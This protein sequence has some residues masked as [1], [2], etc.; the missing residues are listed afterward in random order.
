M[1]MEGNCL[2]NNHKSMRVKI[3]DRDKDR[4]ERQGVG[5]EDRADSKRDGKYW[6]MLAI[7][8]GDIEVL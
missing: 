7:Q 3:R 5:I 6:D 8:R 1:M 4:L 2:N